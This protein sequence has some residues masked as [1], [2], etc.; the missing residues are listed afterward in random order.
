VPQRAEFTLAE[1]CALLGTHADTF[2]RAVR[3]LQLPKLGGVRPRRYPRVT[4]VAVRDAGRGFGLRTANHYLQSVKGFSA[5]LAADGRLQSDPLRGLEG[6]DAQTDVR[7]RRRPPTP[8]EFNRLIAA[9]AGGRE[10]RGLSG[11]QRVALY[12][13]ASVSG[14]RA[15]ELE[16]L[17]PEAF[18]LEGQPSVSVEA[19]ATKNRQPAVQP[20]P[21]SVVDALQQHLAGVEAG[22]PA[23]PGAW[24]RDAAKL[25]Q[26]DLRA[27]G[28]AYRDGHGRVCDFHSLRSY[29]I[30]ALARSGVHPRV[31]QL[32]ARHSTITLTLQAYT[33]LESRD[34]RAAVEGLP[35]PQKPGEA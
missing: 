3:R 21:A 32:L 26:H 2:T 25:L 10:L 17:T 15:A 12:L 7:H 19:S 30:T 4:V 1:A 23:F 33:H 35:V 28:V 14:L 29:Y 6:W 34:L 27:A 5:W 18:T 8:E 9:T 20:L 24:R 22:N 13:L 16:S 31:A 11:P